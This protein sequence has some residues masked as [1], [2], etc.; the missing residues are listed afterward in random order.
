[1]AKEVIFRLINK[2][3]FWYWQVIIVLF[4]LLLAFSFAFFYRHDFTS[5]SLYMMM[6]MGETKFWVDYYIFWTLFLGVPPSLLVVVTNIIN[7]LIYS[8]KWITKIDKSV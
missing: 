8:K 6:E 4:F 7:R 2:I 1:M 5:D 3:G